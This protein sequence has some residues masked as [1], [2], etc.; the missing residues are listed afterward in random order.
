MHA[1]VNLT[2]N[3]RIRLLTVNSED[4]VSVAKKPE[5]SPGVR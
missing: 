5:P 3:Y 1:T 2:V 4:R